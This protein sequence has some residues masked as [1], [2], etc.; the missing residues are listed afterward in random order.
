MSQKLL[1]KVSVTG[2]FVWQVVGE[3]WNIR[4]LPLAPRDPVPSD[5]EVAR[6]QTPK[7]IGELASEIGIR[8]SEVLYNSWQ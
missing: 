6:S 1:L 8:P 3:P 2:C 7:G 5:I 4:Y